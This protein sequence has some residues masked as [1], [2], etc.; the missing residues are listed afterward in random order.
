VVTFFQRAGARM[1]GQWIGS[2][3]GT[4]DGLLVVELDDR[5]D[6]Y[7]GNAFAYNNDH[8][9][10]TLIGPVGFKKD[11]TKFSLKV[12]LNAL[13]RGTGLYYTEENFKK[14]YPEVDVPKHADTEWDVSVDTIAIK[15]KTDI[16]TAGEARLTAS[17]GPKQ[18]Q[19]MPVPEVVDWHTFKDFIS[20]KLLHYNCLYRGQEKNSWRLRTSFHRTNRS[21]LLCFMQTDLGHL[22]RNLAGLTAHK[23][24]LN[25]NL[26]YA[27]FLSLVQHHGYPTP[28][29]DWSRSPFVAAYFSYNN[30]T[31]KEV[32]SDQKVRIHVF[33]APLWNDSFEK[34]GVIA[35]GFL[36]L[37]IL[38]PLPINNPRAVPQQALSTVTNVDERLIFVSEK[39]ST[40]RPTWLPLIYPRANVPS[41]CVS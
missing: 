16:D 37:T 9:A 3:S 21:D 23:F 40:S 14:Q 34:A 29:L 24:N 18:S 15:W 28:L 1:N 6:H 13:V 10:P 36:H 2:Y 32:A 26:D 7:G 5:G 30:L 20:K 38:E 33:D 11:D 35:P 31:S 17:D 22:H 19:L 27:S 12:P 4:N 39:P 8:S 41:S 25:D